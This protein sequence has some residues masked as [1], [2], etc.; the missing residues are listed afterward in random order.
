MTDEAVWALKCFEVPD[1]DSAILGSGDN[2]LE[3]W[4]E[5]ARIYSILMALKAP[6]KCRVSEFVLVKDGSDVWFL[7]RGRRRGLMCAFH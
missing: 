3:V 1:H 7:L 5:D 4:I 6:L 2:L